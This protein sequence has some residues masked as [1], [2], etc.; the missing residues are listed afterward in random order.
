MPK[1]TAGHKH[2]HEHE[3]PYT[4][5]SLRSYLRDG[6]HNI[7]TNEKHNELLC[8]GGVVTTAAAMV[9][10]LRQLWRFRQYDSCDYLVATEDAMVSSRQV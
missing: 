7:G 3:S 8:S 2:K 9:S 5:K 6:H 1:F 4:H 10:S